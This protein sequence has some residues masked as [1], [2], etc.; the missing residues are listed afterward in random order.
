MTVKILTRSHVPTTELLQAWLQHLRDFDTANPGCH[1]EIGIEVPD[2]PTEKAIE[3]LQ[4][5]P[6]FDFTA[7][8]KPPKRDKP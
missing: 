8:Y 6:V 4:V 3:W 7:V 2:V 5:N 1:F